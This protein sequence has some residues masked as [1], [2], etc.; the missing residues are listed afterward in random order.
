MAS[1]V[2][3]TTHTQEEVRNRRMVISSLLRPSIHGGP[4]RY[5]HIHCCDKFKIFVF[6]IASTTS[7]GTFRNPVPHP[8]ICFGL[9]NRLHVCH[10]RTDFLNLGGTSACH[11]SCLH[12]GTNTEAPVSSFSPSQTAEKPEQL[13]RRLCRKR[14]AIIIYTLD[15]IWIYAR[16]SPGPLLTRSQPSSLTTQTSPRVG[17]S[18]GRHFQVLFA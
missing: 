6:H 3:S 4:I 9:S 5:Q 1:T 14:L 7:E 8:R 13:D 11:P 15:S 10:R 16:S 18:G 2:N 12:G 17:Q